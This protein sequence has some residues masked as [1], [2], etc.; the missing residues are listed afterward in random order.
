MPISAPPTWEG[1]IRV[2]ENSDEMAMS[3]KS[4]KRANEVFMLESTLF[5]GPVI[6]P[7]Q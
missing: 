7:R 5:A 3:V 6:N 4:W 1:K 2:W